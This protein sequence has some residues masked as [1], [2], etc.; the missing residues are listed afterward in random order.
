MG[1]FVNILVGCAACYD[2]AVA[3]VGMKEGEIK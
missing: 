3:W 1:N 2:G